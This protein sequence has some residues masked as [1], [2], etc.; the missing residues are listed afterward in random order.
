MKILV[1]LLTC[2]SFVYSKSYDYNLDRR[3]DNLTVKYDE[4]NVSVCLSL[5]HEH[6]SRC[7]KLE[8]NNEE[9]SAGYGLGIIDGLNGEI[10]T[11][12]HCCGLDKRYYLHYYRYSKKCDDW[13]L[14]KK[15][16]ANTI[17][18]EH[19]GF[20]YLTDKYIHVSNIKNGQALFGYKP[21]GDDLKSP[22]LKDAKNE[23]NRI[24]SEYR[25]QKRKPS[26]NFFKIYEILS[27]YPIDKTNLVQYNNFAYY[28]EQSGHNLEAIYLLE[29]ILQK[30][31]NRTVAYYNLGDA[32][33][34]IG[35]KEK[36]KQAYK[37]YIKQMKAKGKEKRI[38]KIVL[39]RV[40]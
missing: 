28:L 8:P 35:D 23:L 5:S 20:R 17:F 33:W 19:N 15:I 32:Y 27:L 16:E 34:A 21:T 37:T 2:L 22:G 30:Y 9:P 24:V 40:E 7:F 26:V 31:P 25:K 11:D 36:A 1:L 4:W 29:K 3:E 12:E 14:Y 13:I 18:V 10:V 38:P 6:K 39:Q